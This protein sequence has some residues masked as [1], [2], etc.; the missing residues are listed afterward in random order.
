MKTGLL[1]GGGQ[2]GGLGALLGQ[3]SGSEVE[4]Q[5]LGNLVLELNLSPKH[6]RGCPGLGKSETVVLV[7]VLGL[8]V[9]GDS[10]FGV[11]DESSLEGHAGGRGGLDVES[12]TVDGEILAQEVIGGLSEV[13]ERE[14]R[15]RDEARDGRGR[16]TFQEG[17]TG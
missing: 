10:G 6:I 11:P 8:D 2:Q 13:L 3:Q 7:V 4:L 17:G 9:A 5:T 12:S 16:N 1:V 14:K 15:V